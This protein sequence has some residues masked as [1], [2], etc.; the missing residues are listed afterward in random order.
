MPRPAPYLHSDAEITALLAAA[1]GLEPPLRA[2]TLETVLGLLVVVSRMRVG[3]VSSIGR[4]EVELLRGVITVQKAK[5]GPGA[6]AADEPDHHR[7]L[8]GMPSTGTGR[9]PNPARGRSSSAPGPAR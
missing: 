5:A 7:C 6:V 2:A 1:R 4:G 8:R 3:E 9:I